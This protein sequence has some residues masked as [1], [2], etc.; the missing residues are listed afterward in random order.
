[1]ITHEIIDDA[2]AAHNYWKMRLRTMINSK[3]VDMP[4]ATIRRDDECKFGK[5]LYGT[6]LSAGDKHGP[7]YQ[8]ILSLHRQFHAIAASVAQS[9][10]DGRFEDAKTLMST[11]GEYSRVTAKLESALTEWKRTIG[12]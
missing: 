9:A 2:L 10:A 5:W 8:S 3:N 1:M 6:S 7:H 12:P 11:E 4:V